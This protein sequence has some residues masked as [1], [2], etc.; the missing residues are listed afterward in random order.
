MSENI[1]ITLQYF[2]KSLFNFILYHNPLIWVI[3]YKEL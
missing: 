3:M 1:L 2:K